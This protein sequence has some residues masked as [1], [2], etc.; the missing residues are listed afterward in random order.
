MRPGGHSDIIVL[1]VGSDG[2]GG[3][4]ADTLLSRPT[5]TEQKA[6]VFLGFVF[7]I[8]LLCASVQ[9]FSTITALNSLLGPPTLISR[10]GST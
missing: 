2:R 9:M 1:E 6:D 10:L 3:L 5:E 4:A 7:C 8:Y